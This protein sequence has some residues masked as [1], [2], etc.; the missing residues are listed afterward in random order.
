MN[1]KNLL[2]VAI[3]PALLCGCES[4]S[5]TETGALAG[6][7]V[8]AGAGAIVGHALGN[9]GAG[10]LVGAAAGALSGGLIGHAADKSEERAAAAAQAAHQLGLVDIAQMA[11]QHVTDEVI[12]NQ[13]RSTGSVFQMSAQD[14]IW[15]K[16]NGVSDRVL[17]EML[18]TATRYPGRV[19]AVA[20]A[21]E[22]VYV[23]DE[24]PPVQVGFGY[25]RRWR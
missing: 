2:L 21:Y 9:T 20:P 24:P 15:L 10:A 17:D 8:G 23:V 4:M 7:A 11:Q 6:G 22:R 16:Q 14:T 1:E 19:V 12:I 5:H 25:Y 13:I 18:A 3:A